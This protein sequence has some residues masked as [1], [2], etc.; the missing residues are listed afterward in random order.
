MANGGKHEMI[1]K[2]ER[3]MYGRN[4]YWYRIYNP[5]LEK[6]YIFGIIQ[7]SY[8]IYFVKWH[9]PKIGHM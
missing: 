3:W 4:F 7:F 2:N 8:C 1:S 6:I 9:V 5:M